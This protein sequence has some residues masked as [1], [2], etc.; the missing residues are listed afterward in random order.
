MQLLVD[1]TNLISWSLFIICAFLSCWNVTEGGSSRRSYL[2]I[3]IPGTVLVLFEIVKYAPVVH[4]VASQK[5]LWPEAVIG[6]LWLAL[7]GVLNPGLWV[8]PLTTT[9]SLIAKPRA[10][11]RYTL[12][13]CCLLAGLWIWGR[14]F[15]EL[16]LPK[17][18]DALG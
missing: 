5:M 13:G 15:D 2:W 9:A 3:S 11:D 10:C 16:F 1:A 14:V 17:I 7:Y 4:S 18:L 8:F 12:I 6:L